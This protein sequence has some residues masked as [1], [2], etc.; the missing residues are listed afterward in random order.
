MARYRKVELAIALFA[1][2]LGIAVIVGANQTI[3]LTTVLTDRIGAR[4]FAYVIGTLCAIGGAVLFVTLVVR[5]RRAGG[6]PTEPED[7]EVT[8]DD[9]GFPAASWRAFAV[10]GITVGYALTFSW[11]GYPLATVGVLAAGGAVMGARRWPALL[12]YPVIYS[13]ATYLLFDTVLR[14]RLPEG[15]LSPLIE[16]I[17][18]A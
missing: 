2:I 14:V 15:L 18:L 13:I 12:G 4:G 1:V 10:F 6:F 16:A 17:G 5:L 9:A 8:G 7:P 11:L 3:E